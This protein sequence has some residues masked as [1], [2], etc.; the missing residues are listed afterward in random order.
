MFKLLVFIALFGCASA[1]TG[2][3][4]TKTVETLTKKFVSTWGTDQEEQL[5]PEFFDDDSKIVFRSELPF[6]GTYEGLKGAQLFNARFDRT[7]REIKFKVVDAKFDEAKGMAILSVMNDVVFA[8]SSEWSEMHLMLFIEWNQHTGKVIKSLTVNPNIQKTM[9]TYK[10]KAEKSLHQIINQFYKSSN[11]ELMDSS[12]PL[13][14]KMSENIKLQVH[15]SPEDSSSKTVWHGKEEVM[16]AMKRKGHMCAKSPLC[17]A[18]QK[19]S[20]HLKFNIIHSDD[21]SVW[22]N[23]Q[24][25]GHDLAVD[26]YMFD[27]DGKLLEEQVYMT[28]PLKPWMAGPWPMPTGETMSTEESDRDKTGMM[29]TVPDLADIEGVDF[30]DM[31][32]IIKSGSE[33]A[34]GGVSKTVEELDMDDYEL[35]EGEIVTDKDLRSASYTRRA[36]ERGRYNLN[37]LNQKRQPGRG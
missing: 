4:D 33:L 22:V 5:L 26:H 8:D 21:V 16:A 36:F 20:Y 2:R 25:M 28:G 7:F 12:N 27:D 9:A 17:Q 13:W 19:K 29:T 35:S 34:N 18:L 11:E 30:G 37:N 24:F 15:I 32:Q 10:T 6:G 14:N 3:A 1:Y 23:I 31:T